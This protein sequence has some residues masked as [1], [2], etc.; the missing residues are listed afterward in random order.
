MMH[1]WWQ[2]GDIAFRIIEECRP[3][4]SANSVRDPLA[5][6][7][8]FAL[9]MTCRSLQDYALDALWYRQDSL[10]ML[11]QCLPDDLWE[12]RETAG[13]PQ[14]NASVLRL[15]GQL[16]STILCVSESRLGSLI[17]VRIALEA[18][19]TCGRGRLDTV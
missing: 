18:P 14:K 7:T 5:R 6:R 3:S 10:V 2:I 9:A 8:L 17:Y 16:V 11:I 4:K 19:Q 1:P 13:L 15:L 12:M